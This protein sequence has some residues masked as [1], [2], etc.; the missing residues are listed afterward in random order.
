MSSSE[1]AEWNDDDDAED[2]NANGKNHEEEEEDDEGD[3]EDFEQEE[4]EE[5]KKPAAKKVSKPTPKED[6]DDDDDDDSSEDDDIPLSALIKPKKA[7]SSPQKRKSTASKASNG[8]SAKKKTKATK[9]KAP[10]PP[11]PAAKKKSSSSSKS[12]EYAS[13]ALYGTDCDKGLLIQR[14]L[15]RWWYAYE[16][17]S[18][19]IRNAKPPPNYDTLDGFPGVFICT[20]GDEVGKILDTRSREDATRKPSFRNFALQ[21][22][23]DLRELLLTAL[24]EQQ[25]QLGAADPELSKELKGLVKWATKLNTK[26][27]DKDARKILTAHRLVLEGE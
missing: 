11:P 26:K 27:A 2:D 18:A 14:L 9:K 6:D 16:W 8:S 20:K 22:A 4:D 21:P 12:Y 5:D 13:A 25:K 10:P 24:E 23:E 17:P 15:C 3:D 7:A 1:E 19:A